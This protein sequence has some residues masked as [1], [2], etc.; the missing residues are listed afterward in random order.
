MKTKQIKTIEKCDPNNINEQ[1][2]HSNEPILLKNLVNDWPAVK[3]CRKSITSSIQYL[4]KFATDNEISMLIGE[5][6]YNGKLFYNSDHNGF[7][8]KQ[9]TTHLVTMLES[10]L[11][12]QQDE[13]PEMIFMG[14]T[15]IDF[16][17]PDFKSMNHLNIPNTKPIINTWIGSQ[18]TVAAHF[19][20]QDNIACVVAG[21]RRFTLFPPNQVKN[22]YISALDNGP[23]GRSMSLVDMKNPDFVKHP[24]FKTALE[25]VI[26]VELSPG[27]A[28]FIPSIWWHQVEALAPLNMLV[29]YWWDQK[30]RYGTSANMAF[31]HAVLSMRSLPQRQRDAWLELFK[32]YIFNENEAD[33]SHIPD[34]NLGIL[35]KD[36]KSAALKLKADLIESLK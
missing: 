33:L 30:P 20:E 22:L 17:L 3:A 11:S 4:R 8:F 7:N 16:C 34:H 1:I 36:S 15:N 23:G 5:P 28:I 14:S 29:N 6:E 21:K 9:K 25:H 10:I 19:D 24:K 2:I 35:N 26:V 13:K 12:A 32:Y 18:T 31:K 27:D